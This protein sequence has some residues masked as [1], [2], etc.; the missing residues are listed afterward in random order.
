MNSSLSTKEPVTR[1][2]QAGRSVS[3]KSVALPAEH[4]S[5]SLVSEPILLG[6]LIAPSWAGVALVVAA[7]TLFLLNRPLKIFWA[8]SRRGRRYQRTRMAGRFLLIYGGVAVVG[9]VAALILGGWRP[10]IPFAVAAPLLLIFMYYDQRPGR[11]WQAELLAPA[12]FASIVSSVALAGGF[13]WI[14]SA[15][16]WGFMIARAVPAVLFV[17][18]RLRLDKQKSVSPWG[19]A[20]AHMLAVGLVA[21]LVWAGWLPTT[22]VIATLFLWG[23]ALWGLSGYRWR[24]SVKALGFLETG[25]GIFVVLL[26][27]I[28]FWLS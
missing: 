23:R 10:F 7:F 11:H 24:S 6:L 3:Y 25:V 19:V 1:E 18:A 8:D 28:G 17:R 15:A 21:L 14:V 27:A 4:G 5:W 12:A 22:A 2:P 20:A 16:L 13:S 9:G 26:V